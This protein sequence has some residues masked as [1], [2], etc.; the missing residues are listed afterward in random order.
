MSEH[1]G[2]QILS[3]NQ[4]RQL[5][6]PHKVSLDFLGLPEAVVDLTGHQIADLTVKM[7]QL[8][9]EK[10]KAAAEKDPNIRYFRSLQVQGAEKKLQARALAE[11]AGN[12]PEKLKA[13]PYWVQHELGI[14]VGKDTGDSER[15][16]VVGILQAADKDPFGRAMPRE[17][18]E[19]AKKF[20]LMRY[21]SKGAGYI[22]EY[23]SLGQ[24]NISGSLAGP[25][26]EAGPKTGT[27]TLAPIPGKKFR[28]SGKPVYYGDDGNFY[29]IQ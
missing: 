25:R 6:T 13:L 24:S 3:E 15:K 26:A 28:E 16:A 18:Y 8:E 9:I 19:E 21:P 22:K 4:A 1:L 5:A 27:P 29:E 11:A 14:S 7:Q 20:I 23:E 17:K 2:S 12:D 10:T